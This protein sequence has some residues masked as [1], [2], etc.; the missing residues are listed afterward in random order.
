MLCRN[1]LESVSDN[2]IIHCK[3][4]NC[5]GCTNCFIKGMCKDCFTTHDAK[6][7][8]NYNPLKLM[9]T[10]LI[11]LLIIFSSIG[12]V[13]AKNYESITQDGITITSPTMMCNRPSC[14][15]DVLLCN[16]EEKTKY[17]PYKLYFDGGIE[18][19]IKKE[20]LSKELKKG[21]GYIYETIKVPLFSNIKYGVIFGDV[22]LDP[23]INSTSYKANF[24]EDINFSNNL[25]VQ[26]NNLTIF[27][28]SS[29]P[30][31][32]VSYWDMQNS[33]FIDSWDNNNGVNTG[34]TFNSNNGVVFNTSGNGR[35]YGAYSTNSDNIEIFNNANLNFGSTTDYSVSVWA[36]FNTKTAINTVIW[37]AT[38]GGSYS[39]Y[40]IYMDTDGFIHCGMDGVVQ[41]NNEIVGNVDYAGAGWIHIVCSVDRDNTTG[42]K[43]YIN[44]TVQ[45]TGNPTLTDSID[46]TN[47][48]YVGVLRDGVGL[49]MDGAIDELKIINKRM[50]IQNVDDLFSCN[51]LNGCPSKGIYNSKEFIVNDDVINVTVDFNSNNVNLD[52]SFDNGTNYFLDVNDSDVLIITNITNLVYNV[53]VYPDGYFSDFNISLSSGIDTSSSLNSGIINV[54]NMEIVIDN[55]ISQDENFYP[56]A[57]YTNSTGNLIT[58]GNCT[59]FFSNVYQNTKFTT[60]TNVIVDK[61]NSYNINLTGLDL[62]GANTFDLLRFSICRDSATKEDLIVDIGTDNTVVDYVDVPICGFNS[63]FIDVNSTGC[64]GVGFCDVTLSTI[65]KKDYVLLDGNI[66]YERNFINHTDNLTNVSLGVFISY[67]NHAFKSCGT[68]QIDVSCNDDFY[69]SAN[70]SLF[71]TVENIEPIAIIQNIDTVIEGF[72]QF[73]SGMSV[74]IFGGFSIGNISAFFQDQDLV[75][76]NLT[77]TDFN[78]TVL[79]SELN[80]SFVQFNLTPATYNVSAFAIDTCNLTDFDSGYFIVNDCVENWFCTNSTCN[81]VFGVNDNLGNITTTCV[82]NN[83]CGTFID[84]P[85]VNGTNYECRATDVYNIDF[86]LSFGTT[87]DK[88]TIAG[89]GLFFLYLAL[90]IF[91]VIMSEISRMAVGGVIVVVTGFFFGFMIAMQISLVIAVMVILIMMIAGFSQVVRFWKH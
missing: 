90:I 11:L 85:L 62:N 36:T 24:T 75:L 29:V 53:S 83:S 88:T 71:V 9:A 37:K 18:K 25:L 20:K 46:N 26:D 3:S 7:K 41:S 84:L 35:N 74:Q 43:L 1:C 68:Q 86:P 55:H 27:F 10:S 49:D 89:V 69:N 72:Q 28:N 60:G 30:S 78:G 61:D 65:S 23:F 5:K 6:V 16:N 39:G 12:F 4:C 17:K 14:V 31:N 8:K 79:F 91:I 21:C 76:T 82:D 33:S 40:Y 63:L 66:T 42:Y 48:L 51:N 57:N 59:A 58:T 13:V 54:S 50:T 45:A 87:P 32:G 38:D 15:I 80:S 19:K 47:S 34:V 67:Y 52:V 73:F 22:D 56:F 2:K 81:A 64:V 77:I 44:G 70:Y